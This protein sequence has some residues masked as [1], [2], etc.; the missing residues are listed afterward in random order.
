MVFESARSFWPNVSRAASTTARNVWK[1]ASAGLTSNVTR[2]TPTARS[3]G[4]VAASAPST[5]SRTVA[6]WATFERISATAGTDLA[7]TCGGRRRQS[8]DDHLVHVAEPDAAGLDAHA[9]RRRQGGLRLAVAGRVVAVG[10][11]HDPLLCVVGEERRREPE[12][13]A[14]VGRRPDR[15]RGEAVDVD[16]LRGQPFDEGLLA[17]RH[18][19][20]DVALRSL[21]EGLPQ[22]GQRVL[23]SRV[24]DRVGEV[25]DED[26]R[27]P[28]DRQDEL[29]A[30]E[31][32]DERGEEQRAHDE[33][34]P[35]PAGAHP[36]ARPEV[37][38]D[39]E[40]DG[41]DE[42][43]ERERGIECD[44]HQAFPSVAC[45]PNLAPIPRRN[46]MSV[47]RW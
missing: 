12:R 47:S 29:E 25:H 20:R 6:V 40:D 32:E 26:R 10:E 34:E 37:Q 39:R 23:P 3:T 17:E 13:T 30:G 18:D 9:A 4:W 28:V 42:Q 31:R 35:A 14:D 24:P 43:Q 8:L 27:E 45:R 21:L 38:P 7:E 46:R 33:G 41:R 11:Q 16:Q 44:P 1:P 15:C 5:N 2:V 19:P 36:S 22:E